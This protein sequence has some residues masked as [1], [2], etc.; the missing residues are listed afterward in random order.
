VLDG[1]H[2]V[3]AASARQASDFAGQ[4]KKLKTGVLDDFFVILPY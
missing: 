1:K 2:R 4:L 3:P